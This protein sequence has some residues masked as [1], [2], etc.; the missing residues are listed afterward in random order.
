MFF[1]TL[2]QKVGGMEGNET[3]VTGEKTPGQEPPSLMLEASVWS[4][5][6]YDSLKGMM[7]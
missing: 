1:E 2:V 7:T 3:K 6:H 4:I 5:L